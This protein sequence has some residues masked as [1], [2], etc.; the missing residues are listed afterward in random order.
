MFTAWPYI[1]QKDLP[2]A[3]RL[4]THC[5]QKSD[6]RVTLRRM[7]MVYAGNQ[8]SSC[9][10]DN[11]DIGLQDPE[12][13][14]MMVKAS[15]KTRKAVVFSL[16]LPGVKGCRRNLLKKQGTGQTPG[17]WVGCHCSVWEQLSRLRR[18]LPTTMCDKCTECYSLGKF[19]YFGILKVCSCGAKED[20]SR[21][22]WQLT[23]L[24]LDSI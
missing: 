18:V 6:P 24:I 4:V 16:R 2:V 3:T 5:T 13:P 9:S 11:V 8:H 21:G 1:T 15:L 23:R 20:C 17:R 22:M 14:Q 7:C 19:K 10:G 12:E